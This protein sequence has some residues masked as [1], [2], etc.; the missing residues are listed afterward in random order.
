MNKNYIIIG[1]VLLM[2]VAP[3]MAKSLDL[4]SA[5]Q[6]TKLD[7]LDKNVIVKS[8]GMYFKGLKQTS[9]IVWIDKYKIDKE[10]NRIYH[11]D[12]LKDFDKKKNESVTLEFYY[13]TQPDSI[14]H[15]T[16]SGKLDRYYFPTQWTWRNNCTNE[17]CS[18]GW[19]TIEVQNIE[20]GTGSST[21]PISTTG[22]TWAYSGDFSGGFNGESSYVDTN[23]GDVSV[24][25]T[26][27]AWAYVKNDQTG[28]ILQ[29][30]TGARP[31]ISYTQTN[32]KFLMSVYNGTSFFKTYTQSVSLNT[33]YHICGSYVNDTNVSI[34]LNG[35]YEDSMKLNGSVHSTSGD[36]FIGATSALLSYFNGSIDEVLITIVL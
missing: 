32:N 15:I 22:P 9:P 33:W 16:H 7:T 29:R 21:F 20:K 34:Y 5:K 30:T 1:I 27:C 24:N 36:W 8:D 10:G 2:L 19:V 28:R 35:I 18:G 12:S 13:D 6:L 4:V 14:K 31:Y 3:I 11:V 17:I 23:F 25:F 26:G